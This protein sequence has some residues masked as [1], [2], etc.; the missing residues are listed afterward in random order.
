MNQGDEEKY[1]TYKSRR[2]QGVENIFH[3]EEIVEENQP[4]IA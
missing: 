4:K 2:Q 1:I 3:Q